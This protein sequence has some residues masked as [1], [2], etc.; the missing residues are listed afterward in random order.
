[1]KSLENLNE[2]LQDMR[3]KDNEKAF[4]EAMKYVQDTDC[5]ATF[6]NDVSMYNLISSYIIQGFVAGWQEKRGY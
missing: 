4:E 5:L 6:G 2:T 1:M 3:T